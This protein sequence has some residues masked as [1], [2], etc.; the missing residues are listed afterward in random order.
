MITEP[1]SPVI[2]RGALLSSRTNEVSVGIYW[3]LEVAG[4]GA[5]EQIPTLR[6][7]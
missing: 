5:R 4:F 7:G 3:Q 1:H 6:A 2:L